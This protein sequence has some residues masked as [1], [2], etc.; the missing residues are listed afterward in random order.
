MVVAGAGA[1]GH[2]SIR[3]TKIVRPYGEIKNMLKMFMVML[4]CK[5]IHHLLFNN[6]FF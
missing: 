4:Y 5:N 6:T 2:T 1:F 3:A